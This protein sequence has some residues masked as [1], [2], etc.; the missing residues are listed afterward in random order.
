MN[1]STVN[2]HMILLRLVVHLIPSNLYPNLYTGSYLQSQTACTVNVHVQMGIFI[3]CAMCY[4]FL[5]NT[6][7]YTIFIALNT[8]YVSMAMF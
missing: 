8:E 3:K 2:P 5:D 7:I 6:V 4:V 1:Q